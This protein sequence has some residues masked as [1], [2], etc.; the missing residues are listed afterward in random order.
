LKKRIC[1]RIGTVPP[2][3]WHVDEHPE[4]VTITLKHIGLNDGMSEGLSFTLTGEL[5]IL[6]NEMPSDYKTPFLLQ[7]NV[8]LTK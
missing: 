6:E 5:N 3:Q 4:N 8:F 1:G 7:A 2:F